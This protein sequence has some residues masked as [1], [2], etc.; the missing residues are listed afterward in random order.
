MPTYI[1][2]QKLETYDDPWDGH[3]F[4]RDASRLMNSQGFRPSVSADIGKVAVRM[5]R[6]GTIA[7]GKKVWLEIWSD[8]AGKPNAKIVESTTKKEAND[9][10]ND[11]HGDWY[12]FE[13]AAGTPLVAGTTYHIIYNGDYAL[14]L[15]NKIYSCWDYQVGADPYPYGDPRYDNYGAWPSVGSNRDFCFKEYYIEPLTFIP[16]ITII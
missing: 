13:F 10:T 9:I 12:E 16:K 2:D 8:N 6:S 15:G 11:T 4:R 5:A 14:D 1:L 3:P 7:A